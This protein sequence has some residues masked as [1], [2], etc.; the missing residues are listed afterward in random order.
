MSNI[1]EWIDEGG[2]SEGDPNDPKFLEIQKRWHAVMPKRRVIIAGGRDYHNYDA[3]L[4]AVTESGF[5]ID[6]VVSGGANGVDAMGERW[7]EENGV[8]L[9]IFRADWQTH[10]RAAGPIRNRKMAENA[11]AL[12]ALWDGKS[13]GTKN[14]IETA[15]KHGLMVYVKRIDNA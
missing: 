1:Y 5:T 9:T 11:D 12:I 15:T 3:L 4:E 13:R 2:Y 7:A 8:N 6:V 14:M 10:G